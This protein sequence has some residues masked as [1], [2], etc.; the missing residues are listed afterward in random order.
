MLDQRD[1][2]YIIK[3]HTEKARDPNNITRKWDEKTPYYNHSIWGATT[4]LHETSLPEDTRVDGSQALLYHDVP[5][6]TTAELPAWLS[7]R[8]KGLILGMTFDSS[9][10]EWE[11]LWNRDKEV[12]LLKVYDKTSNMLDSVWMKPERREQHKTHLIRLIDDV[13]HNYG[14]LNI[15]KIARIFSSLGS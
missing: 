4:I 15:L 6:D 10:D 11:N 5:E 9:E 14:D 1:L 8:V 3:A 7:N 12:R 13:E 2:I